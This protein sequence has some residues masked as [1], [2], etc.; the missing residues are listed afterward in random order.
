MMVDI[1]LVI[2]QMMAVN[3]IE[4]TEIQ[5]PYHQIVMN[6]YLKTRSLLN[7]SENLKKE[8]LNI[9]K[10]IP[11]DKAA[12]IED[13]LGIAHLLFL[14]PDTRNALVIGPYRTSGFNEE[15]LFQLGLDAD[16]IM[17]LKQ[18]LIFVPLVEEHVFNMNLTAV[19][20][21]VF[22][23]ERFEVQRIVEEMPKVFLPDK[24]LFQ[25]KAAGLE[26]RM[27]KIEERYFV[28]NEVLNAVASGNAAKALEA[29]GKMGGHEV[30]Q[31]FSVSLRSQKNS[32][33][34]FSSLMRKAIERAGVHPYYID[35]ISTRFS[36]MIEMILDDQEFYVMMKMMIR[37]Y[38]D[39]AVR[40]GRKQYSPVVQKAV[41]FINEDVSKFYT[42]HE[43]SELL[44]LNPSYLSNLFKKETGMTLMH[45]I[46]RHKMMH[47]CEMLKT[48][49][50]SVAQIAESVGIIDGNYFARIFRKQMGCSPTEY[51]KR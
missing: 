7:P 45:Y 25:R 22:Q 40:Y 1:Q 10:S 42:L 27:K 14:L 11:K 31:R 9:I 19:I 4:V 41:A 35:E 49:H 23:K 17:K 13:Y 50:R 28:E 32:L 37:E 29:M 44:N 6:D 8:A 20:S 39:Y 36:N 18:M 26:E 5:F 34:I 12:V 38:C 21:T 33:I 2:R 43:I 46:H 15:N 16:Q 48:T 30:V 24:E 51:R 47:A 3:N